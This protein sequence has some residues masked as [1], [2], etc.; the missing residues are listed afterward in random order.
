MH[1]PWLP[2]LLMDQQKQYFDVSNGLLLRRDVNIQG[3]SMQA[4]FED[5]KEV[6]GVKVPFTIRRSRPD[7][8]FTHKFDLVEHNTLID[9]AKFRK[10]AP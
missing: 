5:Y 6:N 4:Y 9:D 2:R 8:T 10:P 1:M 7:F 3:T